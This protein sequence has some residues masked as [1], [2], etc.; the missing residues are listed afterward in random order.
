MGP[1]RDPGVLAPLARDSHDHTW[2]R[3]PAAEGERVGLL[4]ARERGAIFLDGVGAQALERGSENSLGARVPARD[5][6]GRALEEH[7]FLETIGRGAIALL[8]VPQQRLQVDALRDVHRVTDHIGLAVGRVEEHV[9]I[10][11]E[12]FLAAAAHQAEQAAV[13][14]LLAD[15][16][17]IAIEEW[18]HRRGE[19]FSEVPA[20]AVVRR[21]AELHRGG[22]AHVEEISL[23]VVAAHQALAVLDELAE[24][25]QV[26]AQAL[27]LALLR[28]RHLLQRVHPLTRLDEIAHLRAS[29]LSTLVHVYLPEAKIG[30]S[31]H[32]AQ[33]SSMASMEGN[34]RRGTGP[35]ARTAGSAATDRS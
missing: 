7:P 1:H 21:I 6:A 20:H 32:P 15:A 35:S 10:G 27:V 16:R 22:G 2:R 13:R 5:G 9:A 11:P 12:P 8:A 30:C 19:K 28:R 23:E 34:E 26:V 29:A 17:Q 25:F 31:A 14:L 3:Q 33:W 24:E 18:A 4:L